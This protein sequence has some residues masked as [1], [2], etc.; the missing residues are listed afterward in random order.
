MEWTATGCIKSSGTAGSQAAKRIGLLDLFH[1]LLDMGGHP[2]RFADRL[3]GLRFCC[4]SFR[5]TDELLAVKLSAALGSVGVDLALP[6][7]VGRAGLVKEGLS[8]LFFNLQ[9]QGG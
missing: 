4:F 6:L 1:E 7:M 8:A 5:Q 9:S 3:E 2:P